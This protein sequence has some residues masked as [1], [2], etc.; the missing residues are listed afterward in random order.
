MRG[1]TLI[2]LVV[3]EV[4]GVVLVTIDVLPGWQLVI[5]AGIFIIGILV[6]R[7]AYRRVPPPNR[8]LQDTGEI[9]EDP[10]SKKIVRVLYDPKTGERY[11]DDTGHDS[12][13]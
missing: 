11:Y 6:E 10:V 7:S 8:G 4:I 2:G 3:L 1:G 5:F 9:F 13:Q 12:S